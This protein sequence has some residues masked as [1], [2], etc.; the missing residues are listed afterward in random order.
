MCRFEKGCGWVE[1][2]DFVDVA[3]EINFIMVV[4]AAIEADKRKEVRI[5]KL[6]IIRFVMIIR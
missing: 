2:V 3:E 5:R 6:F 1:K 4:K